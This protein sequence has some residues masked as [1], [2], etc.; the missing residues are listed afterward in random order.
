VILDLKSDD[1]FVSSWRVRR[2]VGKVTVQGDQNGVQLLSL[3]DDN[4]IVRVW[5]NMLP[6]DENPMTRTAKCL[7]H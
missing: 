7:D 2:D 6:Q 4:R 1:P 3:C 5:W